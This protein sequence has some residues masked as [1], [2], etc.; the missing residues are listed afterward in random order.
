MVAKGDKITYNFLPSSVSHAARMHNHTGAW[1]PQHSSYKE[2]QMAAKAKNPIRKAAGAVN[3]AAADAAGAVNKAAASAA[4]G[5]K[6]AVKPKA[7]A[8]KTGGKSKK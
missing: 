4:K 1:A 6:K 7:K 8:S 2:T 5:V 3:N